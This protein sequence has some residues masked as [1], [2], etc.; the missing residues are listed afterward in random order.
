M[1]GVSLEM[2]VYYNILQRMK[3]MTLHLSE[4]DR[5]D[6][7][8]PCQGLK[9]AAWYYVPKGLKDGE[10]RPAIVMAHGFSA[11]KEMHLD[12]FARKF[13]EAGFMVLV[14]DYRFFGA[15]EGEPRGRLL[16]PEQLQDY[17]DAIT[18]ASLREEV[19]PDRIGVWGTS[20]SGGHVIFLAAYDRRIKAVVAQVPLPDVWDT[21]IEEKPAE[22]RNEFLD[23]LYQNRADYVANGK[24]NYIPV[25]APVDQPSFWPLQEWYEGFMDLTRNAPNW[26]NKIT[27]ESLETHITY[28]PTAAIHRISPTP[29]LMIIASDDIITPTEAEKRA[30]ERAKE[31]KKL[32]VVPGRHFEAYKSKSDQFASPAVEWFQQWLM[33]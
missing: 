18:W 13:A 8:V 32:V 33:K 2:S 22:E 9:C 26:A 10:K 15:S 5:Q 19:D 4:Y 3:K 23:W 27:V 7:R 20:Y 14:F 30:F 28:Q 11:V 21:Y 1:L 16:W 17:R 24:I 29:L 12:N 25:A 31:P 6:V